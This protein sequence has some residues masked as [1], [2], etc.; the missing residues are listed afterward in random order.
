MNSNDEHLAG[1]PTHLPASMA[2]FGGHWCFYTD[3]AGIRA[4]LAITVRNDQVVLT[5][6]SGEMLTFTGAEL[7]ML[8]ENLNSVAGRSH[9]V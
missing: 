4:Q 2:M 5:T 3:A 7:G 1:P 8:L 6:A 9:P